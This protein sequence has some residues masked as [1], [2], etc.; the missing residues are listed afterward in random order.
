[1][2]GIKSIALIGLFSLGWTLSFAQHHGGPN[3]TPEQKAEKM[4]D[5]MRTE[6]ALDESKTAQLQAINLRFATAAD[7]IHKNSEITEEQKKEQ[8]KAAKAQHHS[9]LSAVLSEAQ[10]EQL[11]AMKE[12]HRA[13]KD[14][15]RGKT[16][17]QRAATI[18]QKMNEV[19]GLSEEQ[20]EK[21]GAL[22]LGVEQKIEAI[23]ND[24]NMSDEK[25]KEFIKG[26]RKNQMDALSNIL[27]PE[28][29]EKWK[30][31]KQAEH[32]QDHD[33]AE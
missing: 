20:F 16:P 28:Q 5:K 3:G 12:E 14:E 13:M 18:T 26:N 27:T 7:A 15:G 23:R 33:Q 30:A 21:V 32:H 1:M 19:V 6:L 22:N 31:H 9:D 11:K 10:M 8:M 25:K 4:T 17:E 29:V 24:A 2:K